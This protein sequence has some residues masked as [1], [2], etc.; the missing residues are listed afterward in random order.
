MLHI[1]YMPQQRRGIPGAWSWG[2]EQA[3]KGA[4]DGVAAWCSVP[5]ARARARLGEKRRSTGQLSPGSP[6]PPGGLAA[7]GSGLVLMQQH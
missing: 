4:E 5:P 3:G 6:T 7:R 1:R 2:M